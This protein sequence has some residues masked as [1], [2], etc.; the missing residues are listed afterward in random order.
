ML[1]TV[2]QARKSL[3][4]LGLPVNRDTLRRCARAKYL[5]DNGHIRWVGNDGAERT[6]HVASQWTGTEFDGGLYTV[7]LNG[8]Q[9]DCDCKDSEKSDICKHR[10]GCMMSEFKQSHNG[11]GHKPKEMITFTADR[12]NGFECRNLSIWMHGRLYSVAATECQIEGLMV[13]MPKAIADRLGLDSRFDLER[14]LY[15][16]DPKFDWD[17]FR[18]EAD[19]YKLELLQSMY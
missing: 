3:M 4:L 5:L 16:D 14:P 9:H 15:A 7:H 18:H 19:S 10:I 12:I 6:Y 2:S 8:T 11:N 13:T 1:F 17:I